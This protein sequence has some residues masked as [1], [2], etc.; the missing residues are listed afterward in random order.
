[1]SEGTRFTVEVTP[2]LPQSLSRLG[3]LADDLWYSWDR[4]ARNLFARL[5]PALWHV[6]GQS[7]K[8]LLQ[9]VDQQ[10]LDHAAEDPVYLT[11]LNLVLSAYDTYIGQ[12]ARRAW[13]EDLAADDLIAYFC[14]EFGFHE[15]LPIYSGGLGILAGDH[16]KAASDARLPFVAVGLLYRQG[17]F[18]QTIDGDGNQQATYHDADFDALPIQPARDRA[19]AEI[20][21]EVEMPGRVVHVKVWQ[22]KVGHVRLYLLDT[23]VPPNSEADRG[24][25]HRLY[26]GDRRTRLEQEIVLGVGGVRALFALGLAPTVWHINEGH[27]AFLVLERAR[28]AMT[29]RDVDFAAAIE[30]V[31]ASTV[32]TTHTAVP[33]GHDHFADDMVASYFAD[34]CR[35][36]GISTQDLLALGRTQHSHDF[37]MTALA[38]RGSRHQNGVSRIHGGVSSEMLRD[39]WPQVPPS[40]NPIDHVTNGVHALTF[41]APEW[42]DIFERFLGVDWT[43]RLT[44]GTYWDRVHNIPDAMFWSVR[45]Y[46]K[47]RM[48]HL[49]RRRVRDQLIRNRG[50]ESHLERLFRYADPTNPNVLTIGFGRRFAT[51]KRSTLLFQDLDALRRIILDRDRP[52]LF[53]YCGKAH[54]ADQP[55]QDLIRRIMQVAKMPEFVGHILLVEGY[56][57]RLARRL[58]AG[59][60]VWLN[61][62][63]YPL[64]ASGTSGMK[65]SMNGAINLSILDGWWDEGYDGG[66]GWAIEPA[67]DHIDQGKRDA[68]EAR[69][70][71]ELL[72]DH[73][74]PL[75]YARDGLAYSP[76]WVK[77]AKRAMGS[78]LPHYSA[79]RMLD[80]YVGKFYV[81]A[82]RGGRRYEADAWTPAREVA[83]WKARVR[84][85]WAGVT[86]QRADAPAS[87]IRFGEALSVAVDVGLNGL[88]TDDVAVELLIRQVHE[89]SLPWQSHR[90][91]PQSGGAGAT[92]RYA[93]ELSPAICGKLDYRIRA[94]PHHPMLTHPF[95]VGLMRWL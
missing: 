52:V 95:E 46:L 58:V 48:L 32:F 43:Q 62:P 92:A 82:A 60:D 8:G 42:H 51:Y 59:V 56:D 27:A 54:P 34:Y 40:E 30:A 41:V 63:I 83:R 88:A 80:E 24:I 69:T 93:L 16:C 2:R 81:A 6:V 21:I 55:G 13:A 28:I 50:S 5:D 17:Y 35:A 10:R 86:L 31:A 47:S 15:S 90:L 33:A 22:A 70:L 84:E 14:A 79:K 71:Y 12:A 20:R 76:G 37:N 25:A 9:Q 7:P 89:T 94:Y 61:N 77:M 87:R 68:D 45:E 57:L 64:E 75:Y 66:N 23:D 18:T 73:V 29:R 39:L 36:T 49:V 53:I 72:Q 1:M 74:I 67:S 26:G 3:E 44:E 38:I 65:A 19:G 85:A 11:N 91:A 78:V 4:P